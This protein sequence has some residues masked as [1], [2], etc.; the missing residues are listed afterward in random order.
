LLVISC[1]Y[2]IYTQ[3]AS[4]RD[5]GAI[6]VADEAALAAERDRLLPELAAVTRRAEGGEKAALRKQAELTRRLADVYRRLDEHAA[7]KALSGAAA[8]DKPA[9]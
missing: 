1:K 4:R 5:D 7:R 8:A 3:G 9:R 6:L 2:G